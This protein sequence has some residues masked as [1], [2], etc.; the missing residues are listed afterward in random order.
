MTDIDSLVNSPHEIQKWIK[1]ND[2]VRAKVLCYETLPTGF[3]AVGRYLVGLSGF[4]N[5]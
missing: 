3:D 2:R 4:S 5:R 1:C